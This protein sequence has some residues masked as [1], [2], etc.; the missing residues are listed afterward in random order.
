MYFNE[1]CFSAKSGS[2]S[3]LNFKTYIDARF[4]KTKFKIGSRKKIVIVCLC[5]I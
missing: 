4:E 1:V 2:V 5:K 3:F